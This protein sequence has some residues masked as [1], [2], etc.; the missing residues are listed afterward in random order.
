M[1]ID[2]LISCPYCG[3]VHGDL[4]PQVKSY[5]YGEDGRIIK[6]EFFSPVDRVHP[7]LLEAARRIV[8]NQK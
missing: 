4:C 5:T 7:E 3:H 8:E 2:R 1:S 6:V